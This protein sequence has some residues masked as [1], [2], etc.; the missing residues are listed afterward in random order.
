MENLLLE[1][2]LNSQIKHS[3]GVSISTLVEN[4]L[5]EIFSAEKIKTSLRV[6]QD[7]IEINKKFEANNSRF[8]EIRVKSLGERLLIA[9]KSIIPSSEA[10]KIDLQLKTINETIPDSNALKKMYKA[11]LRAGIIAGNNAAK[12]PDLNIIDLGRELNHAVEYS[13][14]EIDELNSFLTIY[15]I[16]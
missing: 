8:L 12:Y 2:K 15:I 5:V 11:K 16:L 10:E 9:Y 6:V 3:T 13:F 14:I 7:L 4:S 1:I